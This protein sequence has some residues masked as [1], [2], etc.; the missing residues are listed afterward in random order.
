MGGRS[1]LTFESQG[2]NSWWVPCGIGAA[3]LMV[4][5][6]RWQL[7]GSPVDNWVL[8]GLCLGIPLTISAPYLASGQLH[9]DACGVRIR[10]PLRRSS[11]PWRD[12]VEIQV[13][14]ETAFHVE[15]RRVTLVLRS[16]RTRKLPVPHDRGDA[17]FDLKV[18]QLRSLHRDAVE[19]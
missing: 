16:G 6:V 5:G 18:A 13:L 15:I 8:F 1:G 19:A 12:V 2:K 3:V 7:V 10:T 17:H 9:V 4:T 14:V 11:I